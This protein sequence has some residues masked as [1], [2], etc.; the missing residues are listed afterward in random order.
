[1]PPSVSLAS[2]PFCILFILA[3]PHSLPPI[4]DSDVSAER[5]RVVSGATTEDEVIVIKNLAKVC[6]RC[7]II[8]EVPLWAPNSEKEEIG[9]HHVCFQVCSLGVE[10]FLLPRLDLNCMLREPCDIV[11]LFRKTLN[12]WDLHFG[13]EL[14]ISINNKVLL[15]STK[16]SLLCTLPKCQFHQVH[17]YVTYLW[18]WSCK[19]Y[20]STS[21]HKA[22]TC[23]LVP[24]R[25]CQTAIAG[26]VMDC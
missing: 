25:S 23:Y 3:P 22:C 21:E 26:D 11:K 5:K 7:V 1:M 2:C 24:Q 15:I 4:Q 8:L 19:G 9:R 14:L 20:V 18:K 16:W 13:A 17:V 10:Y 12:P 6:M